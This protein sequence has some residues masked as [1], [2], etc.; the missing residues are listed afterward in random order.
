MEDFQIYILQVN[1]GLVVFYLLYRMLFSR[2]TFLRIRRVFL[3]YIVIQALVYPM[4][5]LSSRLEQ[6][7]S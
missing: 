4:I 7:N 3:F 6:G 1:A 2:D 5:S